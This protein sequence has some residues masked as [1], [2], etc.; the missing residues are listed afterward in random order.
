MAR[1]FLDA[2]ESN[3]FNGNVEVFGNS[4]IE[5]VLIKGTGNKVQSTV[6]RI[7]FTGALNTYTF[8]ITGNVVTVKSGSTIVATITVPDT[9]AGQTLA[10]ANGS[11][12]LKITGLNNATLGGAAVPTTA[13]VV[14]AQLNAADSTNVDVAGNIFTLV[15]VAGTSA[16]TEQVLTWGYDAENG[17][18]PVADLLKF[19]VDIAKVDFLELGL[20]DDDGV[21]PAGA[22]S[23]ISSITIGDINSDDESAIIIT[24]N[25]GRVLT[26]EASLGSDYLS[27]LGD[28]IID[29]VTGASRLF[30]A[31]K[32]TQEAVAG[33]TIKLT[34]TQ[35]NGGTVETGLT[36]SGDDTIYAGRPELLHGAYIDGGAGYNTLEVDMKGVFA[37]PLQ[38]LNIQQI[39]VQNLP[40]VYTGADGSTYPVLSED[41]AEL[42]SALDLSRAAGLKLL[43]ITEGKGFGNVELGELTIVGIRNNATARL[44]GGFTED[45]TLHYGQGVGAAV[46][47]ELQ[48]GDNPGFDFR[49]AH[50]ASVLNVK[51]DGYENTLHSGDFGGNL[52]RLNVTGNGA[53]N[54][55]EALDGFRDGDSTHPATIDASG[56]TGGVLLKFVEQPFVKF[57]G[58]TGDDVF[59]ATDSD[60]VTITTTNGNNKF[61]TDGSDIVNITSGSGND[62]ISSLGS[63]IVTIDA[64]NGK[65]TIVASAEEITITT[66]TGNDSITVSG[67]DGSIA[68]P[69][70]LLT[71]DA[72]SASATGKNTI[73]LG[74]DGNGV[75]ALEG[76][77][78]A[79]TS[80]VLVIAEDSDLTQVNLGAGIQSVVLNADLK[81]TA[82]DFSERV[83]AFTAYRAAF[84]G[85]AELTLVIADGATFDLSTV[86]NLASLNSS[87]KLQFELGNGAKLVLTAE[88]LHTY[89][90]DDA[91]SGIN[92]TVTLQDAGLDF[93]AT[94]DN[95]GDNV[96]GTINSG[97]IDALV[98]ER[99][100]AGFSRP[101]ELNDSDT[102]NIDS[103]VTPVVTKAITSN[104]TLLTIEGD[105]DLA[106]NAPVNL[107]EGFTVD[108]SDLN[109]TLTGLTIKEFEDAEEIIG[110]G[111]G[112]RINVE[113]TGN[114]GEPGLENGL[115]TSGVAAYVVTNLNGADRIFYTCDNTQDVEVLG[116]QGNGGNSITFADVPWGSVSPTFLLEGDGY[117]DFSGG[118]KAD[119]N[120]NQSNI[121]TLIADFFYPGAPAVVNINNQGVAL[122]LTTTNGPRPLVVDGIEVINAAS[123]TINV[124]D[125]NAEVLS[126]DGNGQLKDVTLVSAFDVTLTLNAPD[127][128]FDSIDASAVAG[129]AS[130][131]IVGEVDLSST[132]LSGID[133]IEL[134]NGA[135]LTLTLDQISAIG[136]DNI[137][138]DGVA[139]TLNI[140]GMGEDLFVA[141][142]LANGI[143]LGVIIIAA[144]DV[145]TLDPDTDLSGADSIVV[146]EGTI[147]N[148]TAAQF[149]QLEGAGSITGAG[150][151]NITGLTQDDI[152]ANGGLDLSGIANQGTLSLAENVVLAA[153][154]VLG[155]FAIK[156]SAN[157]S[158]TLATDVQAHE[159][160]ITGAENTTVKF[161]FAVVGTEVEFDAGV[162]VGIDTAEYSGITTLQV[163]TW[164]VQGTNVEQILANLDDSIIVN[165]VIPTEED[166]VINA[167]HRVVVVEAEALVLGGLVFEDLNSD[168]EVTTL[169]LTLLGGVEIDGD[170]NLAAVEGIDAAGFD[171][172]TINSLGDSVNTIDG[173]LLGTLN[174]FLNV[175]INAAQDFTVESIIFSSVS[176][177]DATATLTIDGAG[178]VVI[179]GTINTLDTDVDDLEIT[180]TGTGSLTLRLDGT[181][182][183]LDGLTITGSITGTD[184]LI[185][186]NE[187]DLSDDTISSIEAV[188]LEDGAELTLTQAQINGIGLG[189]ITVVDDGDQAVLNLVNLGATPFIEA[190]MADGVSLGTVTIVDANVPVTLDPTTDLTGADS[191]YVPE[192]TVL[193]LTAAQFL[194]LEGA[195]TI[196]G[197]GVVN[198]TGLTQAD[199]DAGLDLS[200]IQTQ[201]TITL[202]EDVLLAVATDISDFAIVLA[203]GQTITLSSF[204]QADGRN[205]TGAAATT[206]VLGFTDIPVIPDNVIETAGYNVT[207][208][209]VLDRLIETTD[210]GIGNNNVEE[211]LQNLRSSVEV[212]IFDAADPIPV[213]PEAVTPT[214]RTVFVQPNTEVD[215]NV[216]FNNLDN[217][218]EVATLDLTLLGNAVITGDLDLSTQSPVGFAPDFFQTLTINSQG[219]AANVIGGV[220]A[221]GA[222]GGAFENNLLNV[223]IDAEQDLSIGG[224]VFTSL[225]NNATAN[226]T[227]TGTDDVTIGFLNTADNDV[228][229]LNI[230][231]NGTGTLI[232][233][234]ASPALQLGGDETLIL[235]GTGDMVFG[236]YDNPATLLVDEENAGVSSA[237]LSLINATA[238]SGDLDLGILEDIDSRNFTFNSGTGVTTV[239]V[240]DA[241]LA[242]LP[243]AVPPVTSVWNFDFTNAAAG[244]SLNFTDVTTFTNG[245][246]LNVIGAGANVTVTVSD[247]A[248]NTP[249]LVA[250]LQAINYVDVIDLT[251]AGAVTLDQVSAL[252]DTKLG[253]NGTVTVLN[254]LTA[255]VAP[256]LVNPNTIDTQAEVN[257]L[258]ALAYVDVI[259]LT[260]AGAVTLDQASALAATKL[261]AN[262]TVTVTDVA[263]DTQAEVNA[264]QAL[265][266]VD[267]I[268]MTAAG[269]VTLNQASALAATKLSTNGTVTV[270]DVAINTQAE[271]AALLAK[272]YVD[273]ID[274]T[275]AGAVT[276]D[277]ATALLAAPIAEIPAVVGPPAVDAVPAVPARLSTNG[278]ITVSD[279]TID[280][281]AEVNALQALDYVD[282]ID[283]TVAGAVDLNAASAAAA[284]KLSTN[285][286]V[287]VVDTSANIQTHLVALL[288]NA[289]VDAINSTEDGATI[290]LT[291]A[292][293][294]VPANL[295][296]LAVG[297]TIAVV[298]TMANIN[299]N[300]VALDALVTAVGSKLDN[301]TVADTVAIIQANIVALAA[302]ARIGFITVLDTTANIQ[303]NLVSLLADV[304]IDNID[305]TEN[306][307]AITITAA[308]Q[309][310]AANMAK[311]QAADTITVADTSANIQ[312][313]LAALFADVK[314]DKINSSENTV[315][316]TLTGAQA[317]TANLAKLELADTINVVADVAFITANIDDLA[318]EAKIDTITVAD[319][320]ANL[321]AV[322]VL[323]DL[324]ADVRID[325]VTLADTS[326][327]IQAALVASLADVRIDQIDSTEDGTAIVLTVAQA[328][329]AA[330]TAKLQTAD[331]ITVADSSA[332]INTI[333]TALLANDKIDNID[334]TDGGA[335]ILT[336]AQQSDAANMAKLQAGDN[337]TVAETSA[338]IQASLAALL[339]DAKVDNIDSTENAVTLTI[340]ALQA[341]EGANMDKLQV[342]D[343]I[344]VT[345]VN[346][347]NLDFIAAFMGTDVAK[348]DHFTVSNGVFE[349]AAELLLVD[350]NADG[351]WFDDGAGTFSYWD[352]SGVAEVTLAGASFTALGTDLSIA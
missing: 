114:V 28:L 56:N 46:N 9:A 52:S 284:T 20:I 144:D 201:G 236:T 55:Q 140:S 219:A 258:Q 48:I 60:E 280:T 335:I 145:V 18:V 328:A 205:I 132:E 128:S 241:L 340:T 234:G 314:V 253:T 174:N 320:V 180:H 341:S 262:G 257:A 337:I 70:V 69:G 117:A 34:T 200:G 305:S 333:L 198:I 345:G 322:D 182:L 285:G 38:L 190:D 47:V 113:L 254:D 292:Q 304:R 157:Q 37:Q 235:S 281:Q 16:V 130:L 75:T 19:L 294:L 244:S 291:A 325:T 12:A 153:G 136:A 187:L 41:A 126:I 225:D 33:S 249:E 84:G 120:P 17:G 352:G 245:G 119:A 282:V 134:T 53:L 148:L 162:R 301:I 74:F 168:T 255:P 1:V 73:T 192:G 43:V 158:I 347:G 275:A 195:G 104:L 122:G 125:G 49:V 287:T 179:A 152:D 115:V 8:G 111:T 334:A 212:V 242:P 184:T 142:E 79:G 293:A 161:G 137:S 265:T 166:N 105:A 312:A 231:N 226:L 274:I 67:T 338:N 103:D 100:V 36:T 213:D 13:G 98:I 203:A 21:D 350:V 208:L 66:G 344:T 326:A 71:I 278:T 39:N 24:T 151:V 78:I 59:T 155:D 279:V 164:L 313:N 310:V 62:V 300:I 243:L 181:T 91:V 61:T 288:A 101:S 319:T 189:D 207:Q 276:L 202:A 250:L 211:L 76:S 290:Q 133:A 194:A 239:T 92:G 30:M 65:N 156:L 139:A 323:D 7:E 247:A 102:L 4:G 178:D 232:V 228:D 42:N 121:G 302:E 191:I 298:D 116:L 240:A 252:A 229:T 289:N 2:N 256:A 99:D 106:I 27:F 22:I 261:S 89:L 316:I 221:G 127:S 230:V 237:T 170:I 210:D 31:D 277:Q 10:F 217:D 90:A 307:V 297:D 311:F 220:I 331:T 54:I 317:I 160:V 318:A 260:G 227:V 97:L 303:A 197:L 306:G 295:A 299:A 58:S 147:L 346:L 238:L 40:N 5:G 342:G 149:Q 273:V 171:T 6:E 188:V 264:L 324:T 165:I 68:G 332:N 206:V 218:V 204:D 267:V 172:L 87:V 15:E 129:D 167:T 81:I 29:S 186:A 83:E 131:I 86:A 329:V 135:T 308:Q 183:G 63:E 110:N 315:A 215:A 159:R 50:N 141:P 266:Y 124:A 336:V 80:I 109:G 85:T 193:N 349:V 14:A 222:D 35:N 272:N 143:N 283:I 44:E 123:L 177:D 196:T 138:L 224:I 248:I 51:S 327:A 77:S 330:N 154:T 216:I 112:T 351:E 343:T 25:D 107:G 118:S 64:G 146:P 23:Q 251:A 32:V 94:D 321:N 3:S 173:N 82:E 169:D 108:F 286:T 185:I 11:A 269:A 348:V 176:T 175:E 233:T 95:D 209:Y 271:V 96:F 88:Q 26:A 93:D 72:G 45:I 296:K 339:A 246:T 270:T 150:L 268:D 214:F 309:A 57:V 223:V 259:D 199:V 163:L 263:I